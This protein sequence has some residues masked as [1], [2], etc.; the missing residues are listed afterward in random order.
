MAG[1]LLRFARNDN[2]CSLHRERPKPKREGFISPPMKR[3]QRVSS[4]ALRALVG[5]D[6]P[7][8]CGNVLDLFFLI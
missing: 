7:E 6:P 3:R 4:A 5:D 2:T 8:F 1:R